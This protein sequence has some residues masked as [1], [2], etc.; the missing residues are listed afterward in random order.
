MPEITLE[1]SPNGRAGN[2]TLTIL[3]GGQPIAVDKLDITKQKS[4]AEFLKKLMGE[5]P[6]WD[7]IELESSMLRLAAEAANPPAPDAE[8]DVEPAEVDY[9]ASMP[10]AVVAAARAMLEDKDLLFE[11]S[12]DIE[13]MGV[14]GEKELSLFLYLVGVSRLLPRPLATIVQGLSSSGKSYVVDAVAK[15]F[16][17]ESVLVATSMTPQSLFH[18]RPGSLQNR[19]VVCGERSRR[20]N[21]DTAE[22][23]R[24]L[25]E[26]ISAG[27][28]SKLMPQ[29]NAAGEIETKL[30][31]QEGPISYVESTTLTQIFDEDLNRCLLYHTDERA[32]QTRLI[33]DTLS[34]AYQGER[35]TGD[36]NAIM[37]KHHASQ[38]ML[39]KMEV[40]IPFAKRLAAALPPDRIELRRAFPLL[41]GAIQSL[42]LLFQMQ[43]QVD[44]DGRLV[45]T[46]D[47]YDLARHLLSQ[48]LGERL[49]SRLSDSATRFL[50]ELSSHFGQAQFTSKDAY[51]VTK[52]SKSASKGWLAELAE[53]GHLDLIEAGRGR[54]PSTWAIAN[55]NPDGDA[56]SFLPPS[57]ILFRN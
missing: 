36:K 19:F 51:H 57:E 3:A 13:K 48:P 25:R 22:A 49:G 16:P 5:H 37:E 50:S 38:R 33:I 24:A 17:P 31:E 15:L 9:L 6:D 14:A 12:N 28:L 18:L 54:M 20:E 27:R 30:I 11:V 2:G 10:E 34:E 4:R 47:D 32:T 7:A 53:G 29:K 35:V 43:R 52:F 42:T 56:G 21:D 46:P 40:V 23:T 45:A 26:M 8:P 55:A 39:Q 44:A 41:M 1:W